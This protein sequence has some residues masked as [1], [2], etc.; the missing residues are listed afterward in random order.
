[1]ARI[2]VFAKAPVAGQVKT[3][4]CPPLTAQQAALLHTRLVRHALAAA[5]ATGGTA[6]E[7]HCSPSADDVFFTDCAREFGVALRTQGHGDIGDR[8]AHALREASRECPL[9]LIG[10]DCPARGA[11]DLRDA[12]HALATGMDAVLGPV[13]D[14]G[15]SLIGLTRFD[16][17]LFE[18]IAWSTGQVTAQTQARFAH[19]DFRCMTLPTLWDVNRPADLARLRTS[20][21]ELLAGIAFDALI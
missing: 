1:M 14:G 2:L 3:R 7:Q 18:D 8:M 15:Y 9:L 21:P 16:A 6:V 20:Y 17:R 12:L 11:D 10:S 4:L 13:E 5:C 19:L